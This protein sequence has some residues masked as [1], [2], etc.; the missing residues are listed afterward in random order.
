MEIRRNIGFLTENDGNYENLT[1]EQN[2]NFFAGFYDLD[3]AT[4]DFRVKE[5]LD[6]LELTDRRKQKAGKL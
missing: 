1:V 5:L 6:K 4:K 2:L 3:P